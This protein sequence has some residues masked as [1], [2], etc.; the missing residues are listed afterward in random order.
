MFV[1]LSKDG[2]NM[3]SI[4]NG[5]QVPVIL[6]GFSKVD[7]AKNVVYMNLGFPDKMSVPPT[8]S[9]KSYLAGRGLSVKLSAISSV[10]AI[11]LNF[12]VGEYVE[13]QFDG[14]PGSLVSWRQGF[15]VKDAVGGDNRTFIVPSEYL[16]RLAGR[17]AT[18]KYVV[19][20]VVGKPRT[21]GILTFEIRGLYLPALNVIEVVDDTIDLNKISSKGAV[22]Y[23]TISVDYKDM[24][25]GDQVRVIMEG[26]DEKQQAVTQSDLRPVSSGNLSSNPN[27]RP[28]T[29]IWREEKIKVFNGGVDIYYQAYREGIW[30]NSIKRSLY[31]G[32]RLVGLAPFLQDDDHQNIVGPLDPDKVFG[33]VNVRIPFSGTL[34][35]DK[36]TMF[37][38]D[39]SLQ[40][41]LTETLTVTPGNVDQDLNIEVYL[42]RT[43][44]SYRGKFVTV[45]YQIERTL[46][47]GQNLR[48]NSPAYKFFVGTQQEQDAA[49]SRVLKGAVVGGVKDGSMDVS[50]VRTGTTL[51]VPFAETEE[52]DK[53]TAYWQL[54]E[55]GAPTVLGTQAVVAAN[56]NNDLVFNISAATVNTALNK[57]ATAYYVIER[58]G[59]DG[60]PR[61]FRSQEASF[62]V[63]PQLADLSLPTPEVPAVVDA[64]LNPM[65][66]LN[67]TKVV[68]RPS[69]AFA[70]GDTV[71][72]FFSGTGGA[73]TPDIAT[74]T[75]SSLSQA[76]EFIIPAS[77]IGANM[78]SVVWVYY[79]VT[80][81][82]L[83]RP[84][85]SQENL[86]KIERLGLDNFSAP[87]IAQAP[88]G[89]L[90]LAAVNT[91]IVI[92]L[93]VWLFMAAGQLVWLSLQGVAKDGS[94]LE[95]NVW[96]A[97]PLTGT[98]A[99]QDLAI[100]VARA[101]FDKLA[102][103][104]E[105]EVFA[106]VSVDQDIEDLYAEE[107]P[108]LT[109]AIKSQVNPSGGGST[110]GASGTGSTGGASGTGST[111][112]A[113]GTGSTGGASGAGSTGG[114]SG[115]G[116]TGG[117]SGA[118][119][120]GGASGTGSTGGASGAGSTGGASGT[121]STGGASGT[122]SSGGA[123]G[124][125]SSA[126][127]PVQGV[128]KLE[129]LNVDTYTKC[130]E[131]ADSRN[132]GLVI[133]DL[134]TWRRLRAEGGGK[135]DIDFPA[136]PAGQQWARRVWASDGGLFTRKCYYPDNDTDKDL[137][138][139][140][141][142]GEV[143]YGFALKP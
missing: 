14:P 96:T 84:I 116:S 58:Q 73:G 53:V 140:K 128:S 91:D 104:S 134:A 13:L 39:S 51:T 114:A 67:G 63:G 69:A 110:G 123:S 31:V 88:G 121:G 107:F 44:N 52:G 129:Y 135:L 100:T 26:L 80:R 49:D 11:W 124:A 89:V 21:S 16:K 64:V 92:V 85:E 70:V 25:D 32:S 71:R 24:R 106:K 93:K 18:L 117:T 112:G 138:D 139:I 47:G 68:I 19:T 105:F 42:D 29:F 60:K 61:K 40:N 1:F 3:A 136:A 7:A 57:K 141:I 2:L 113:S 22:K 90:D 28:M 119:S 130:K 132:K 81:N 75:V 34:V 143:A 8:E 65:V 109:V 115:T 30:Y 131:I 15:K 43:I 120:T 27:F 56:V 23:V 77:A 125:G 10:S 95:I 9:D 35:N 72:L 33:Y 126:T 101:E 102:D 6:G 36:I 122:G 99:Q 82:G 5:A 45:Y 83:A 137:S 41:R 54:A 66:A 20:P 78:G 79:N 87:V 142:G 86:F 76:L 55:G 74:Q 48:F 118:G 98:E 37:W 62:S 108:V 127:V 38:H 50:L 133:P 12:A 97:K 103:G 59:L 46:P 111:G 17:T 4:W 94:F